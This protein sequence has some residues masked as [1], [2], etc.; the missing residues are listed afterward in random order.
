MEH[1]KFVCVNYINK[2]NTRIP[3]NTNT[4]IHNLKTRTKNDDDIKKNQNLTTW[5]HSLLVTMIVEKTY[6]QKW[7]QEID[8]IRLFQ[9]IW[10]Q[11][12]YHNT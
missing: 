5:V 2:P 1:I 7:Q 10:N 8:F 9:K 3:Q 4:K 6:E 11:D 12:R